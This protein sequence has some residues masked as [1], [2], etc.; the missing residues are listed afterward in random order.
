MHFVVV[1]VNIHIPEH[2]IIATMVILIS[3][4]Y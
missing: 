1:S 4:E 2:V 3:W